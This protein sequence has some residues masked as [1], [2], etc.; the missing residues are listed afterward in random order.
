MRTVGVVLIL[1]L[2]G[3]GCGYSATRLLPAAY[4][5]IYIDPI[6]NKIP[7]TEEVN[8]RQVFQ[9]NLPGLEEKVTQGII[10]RFLFDGNLKITTK[11]EAADLI[12]KGEL[13]DFYRQAV[14]RQESNDT[15]EEYR[16]NLVAAL[17]VRNRQGQIVWEEPSLIGDATYQ[18][19][20]PG[21]RSETVAV[22]DMVTDF[23]RRV[24]EHVIENW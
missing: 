23:S 6:Q 18:L 20:G 12:L 22:D 24:V 9:T 11:P 1:A 15:V 8:E 5:V 17:T 19:T 10:N 16:L 2:A 21:A 3:S 4:Q 13:L 7:L 14:R